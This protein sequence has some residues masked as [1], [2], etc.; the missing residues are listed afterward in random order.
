[1]PPY[2]FC[3][4][5]V[6]PC[7]CLH[8]CLIVVSVIVSTCDL[9]VSVYL[10]FRFV[11]SLCLVITASPV[12]VSTLLLPRFLIIKPLFITM[13]RVSHAFGS[14]PSSRCDILLTLNHLSFP[15][16]C[17]VWVVL[18]EQPESAGGKQNCLGGVSAGPLGQS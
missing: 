5:L 11:S 18:F 14:Y 4:A 7:H 1:M 8:L 17:S 12:C 9:F 16:S 15:Q 13:P 3:P 2:C 10:G 6:F